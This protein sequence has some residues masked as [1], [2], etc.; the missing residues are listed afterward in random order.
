[1]FLLVFACLS[2]GTHSAGSF[3]QK[4]LSLTENPGEIR[5]TWVSEDPGRPELRYSRTSD[6]QWEKVF[7]VETAFKAGPGNTEYIN[8]AVMSNLIEGETYKY[9]VG[10][11][12]F[13]SE[14][15]IFT[16]NTNQAYNMTRD[17]EYTFACLGDWGVGVDGD[18]TYK[19]IKDSFTTVPISA[20]LHYGD[21]SYNLE[22]DNGSYG[23]YYLRSKDPV[24]REIPYMVVPGDHD[25][26]GNFSQVIGRFRMPNNTYNENTGLYYSFNM[27]HAHIVMLNTV[28]YLMDGME[29]AK[30]RQMEFLKADLAE[31][32]M[33]R[34]HTHWII[35]M[36]HQPLY[37][38]D[39]T[40]TKCMVGAQTLRTA[41]EDIFY[42]NSVDLY[43]SGHIHYYER[44]DPIYNNKTAISDENAGNY[45][46]NAGATVYITSGI[47]GSKTGKNAIPANIADWSKVINDDIGYGLITVYD[48]YTLRWQQIQSVDSKALD[49]LILTKNV[50]RPFNYTEA[51]Y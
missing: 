16:A 26:F 50:T 9:Y 22:D 17:T 25:N 45:I 4:K 37:C 49:S 23:D 21:I 20:L 2:L 32:N 38:S 44:N 1:M 10:D 3:D 29:D 30:A 13:F 35:V 36:G 41:F 11:F 33:H 12:P 46:K 40:S 28:F 14:H 47:A 6:Y 42:Q 19:S 5:V 24:I 48:N 7:G 15:V 27:G 31:A 8:T 43:V 18:L 34:N 39:F 51:F